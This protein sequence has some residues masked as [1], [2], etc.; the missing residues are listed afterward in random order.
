MVDAQLPGVAATVRRLAAVAVSGEGWPARLLQEYALLHLLA[1]ATAAALAEP[2]G[3]PAATVRAHLGVTV[4]KDDVLTRPAVRDR[5]S[6]LALRDDV[7]ERLTVRRVWLRGERTGRMALVM[8]FAMAGQSLDVT[9]VPGTVL[10]SDLHFYPGVVA[11]RALLG[12]R[13][14]TAAQANDPI[15]AVSGVS[16]DQALAQWAVAL[17]GD[18][19]IRSWPVVLVGVVPVL[20]GAGWWLVDDTGSLPL[21]GVQDQNWGLLAKSGGHPVTVLAEVV[22][23]GIRA[24]TT[25][26][27]TAER[28][29][30]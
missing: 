11:L 16:L 15:G 19:L 25:L 23:A 28:V 3:E 26:A 7:E 9:L 24:V 27:A 12:V 30:S 21:I 17:A 13:H 8:S 20:D 29:A 14:A 4:A 5:W 10:D 22:P 18:P 2:S 6:V 1:R